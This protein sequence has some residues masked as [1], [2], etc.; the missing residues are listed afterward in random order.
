M[1]KIKEIADVKENYPYVD[2]YI[3]DELILRA[4][5]NSYGE[6]EYYIESN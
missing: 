2:Y 6:L 3:L 4:Y 5:Y 1:N